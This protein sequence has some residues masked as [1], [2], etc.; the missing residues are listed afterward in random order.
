MYV[1]KHSIFN[2]F[3]CGCSV[4]LDIL[5]SLDKVI[6]ILMILS[7]SDVSKRAVVDHSELSSYYIHN[8]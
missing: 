6:Y 1:K 8:N 4:V 5:V 3:R 7:L 2:A